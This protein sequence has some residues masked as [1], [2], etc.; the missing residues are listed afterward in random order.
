MLNLSPRTVLAETFT[1]IHGGAEIDES[2]AGELLGAVTDWAAAAEPGVAPSSKCGA[3]RGGGC[4][5]AAGQLPP[6]R[7]G[8]LYGLALPA[9]DDLV[10]GLQARGVAVRYRQARQS[11]LDEAELRAISQVGR[12]GTC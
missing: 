8:P 7:G 3:R 4:W 10:A 5:R 9:A 6:R 1:V 11:V 2:L 12:S